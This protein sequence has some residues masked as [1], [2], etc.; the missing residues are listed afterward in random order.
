MKIV[1][2]TLACA[3]A[4][5]AQGCVHTPPASKLNLDSPPPPPARKSEWV[6]ASD[7]E[8]VTAVATNAKAVWAIGPSGVLHWTRPGGAVTFEEARDAPHEDA[9]AIALATD[10]TAYVGMRGGIAWKPPGPDGRWQRLIVPPLDAG[11]TA[12]APRR[13]GGVWVGLTHGFG[14]MHGGRLRLLNRTYSVRSLAVDD[15][16]RVW[17]A[18]ARFGLITVMGD[19]ILEHTTVEGMCA[20]AVRSV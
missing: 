7:L 15:A 19:R 16:G 2:A 11:V 4:L 14:W 6:F 1:L 20:N 9:T 10:G 5:L 12:L 13:A 17:A 18:T 8:N 3:A